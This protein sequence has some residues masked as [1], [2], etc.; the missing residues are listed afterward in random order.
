MLA[1]RLLLQAR[2]WRHSEQVRGPCTVLSYSVMGGWY[3]ASQRGAHEV[4]ATDSLAVHEVV[5]NDGYRQPGC[6]QRRL[7]SRLLLQARLW[8]LSKQVRGPCSTM[9]MQAGSSWPLLHMAKPCVVVK[10][11]HFVRSA[12]TSNAAVQSL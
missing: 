9:C 2:L 10:G 4:M 11:R 3:A 8:R 12:S 6:L 5:T 1:G 7:A